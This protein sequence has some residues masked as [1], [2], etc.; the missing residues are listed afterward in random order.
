MTEDLPS[1]AYGSSPGGVDGVHEPCR[2]CRRRGPQMVIFDR[3]CREVR[4]EHYHRE[5]RACSARW[6]AQCAAA[7]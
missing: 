2:Q 6:L 7:E 5:C 4:G 1:A 3:D